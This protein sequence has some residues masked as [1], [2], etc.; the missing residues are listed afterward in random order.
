MIKGKYI[1][2]A[3]YSGVEID[4]LGIPVNFN[5]Y[6]YMPYEIMKVKGGYKV[7]NGKKYLSD[8]PLSQEEAVKQMREAVIAEKK[9]K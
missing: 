5:V 6:C 8:K 1:N 7:S 3:N 9:N 2:P 4:E